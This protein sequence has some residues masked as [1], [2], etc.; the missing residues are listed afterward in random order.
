MNYVVVCLLLPELVCLQPFE[1]VERG[2]RERLC[3]TSCEPW[4]SNLSQLC[5]EWETNYLQQQVEHEAEGESKHSKNEAPVILHPPDK[6]ALYP[7]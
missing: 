5:G 6:S 7:P 4:D 1:S 3:K 2:L